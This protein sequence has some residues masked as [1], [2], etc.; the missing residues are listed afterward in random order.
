MATLIGHDGPPKRRS[1]WAWVALAACGFLCPTT[2]PAQLKE[3]KRVLILNQLEPLAS[4]GVAE[5]DQAVIAV[6]EKSPYQLQFFTE[7]LDANAP[8]D[9]A[10]QRALREWYVRK[11][12]GHEPDVILAVGSSPLELLAESREE[13][14]GNTPVIFCGSTEEMLGGRQLGARLP[15]AWGVVEPGETLDAA[16]K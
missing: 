2:A 10:T 9:E 16:L 4:P 13:F 5:L 12:H 8:L 14:F 15:G 1:G 11:Y 3:P 6:L 7:N